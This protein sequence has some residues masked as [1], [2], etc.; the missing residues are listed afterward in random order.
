MNTAN[1]INTHF[2][3][4]KWLWKRKQKFFLAQ[5]A[6]LLYPCIW[7]S[8][9]KNLA[10]NTLKVHLFADMGKSNASFLCPYEFSG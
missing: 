3:G 8:V 10:F 1:G 9:Y 7:R 6:N 4:R 5:L 2:L